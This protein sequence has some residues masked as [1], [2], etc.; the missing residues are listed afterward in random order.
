MPWTTNV[1]VLAK[2]TATSSEL[3][4]ALA[5]RAQRGSTSFTLIVPAGPVGHGRELPAGR[6]TKP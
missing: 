4:D 5:A 1:L 6:W 2:V 3:L